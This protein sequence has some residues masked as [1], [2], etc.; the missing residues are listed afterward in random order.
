M[1]ERIL[2]CDRCV[3]FRTDNKIKLMKK[4]DGLNKGNSYRGYKEIK[5]QLILMDNFP[6]MFNRK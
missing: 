6:E 1:M 3:N 4:D 5:R 2:Y